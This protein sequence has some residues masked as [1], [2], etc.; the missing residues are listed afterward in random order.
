MLLLV[1]KGEK[2]LQAK[3]KQGRG[4]SRGGGVRGQV[5]NLPN[6]LKSAPQAPAARRQGVRHKGSHHRVETKLWLQK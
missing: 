4:R 5:A 1:T 2:K 3:T 6:D